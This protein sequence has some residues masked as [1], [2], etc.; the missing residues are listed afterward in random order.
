MAAAQQV[1]KTEPSEIIAG[2]S[3]TWLRTISNYSAADWVLNYQLYSKKDGTALTVFSSTASGTD[4]LIALTSTV[5]AAWSPDDYAA[6][7]YLT[8]VSQ[9]T[10]RVTVWTG[11][12][13]VLQNPTN[14]TNQGD[15][16]THAKRVLDLIEATIEGRATDDILNSVVEGTVIHRLTPEQLIMMRDRYR[17]E[18]ANEL[19]Q[20]K[21]DKGQ[22]TG[23][24]IL[25]RFVR[26]S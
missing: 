10:L 3:A 12:I 20:A 15:T 17:T 1:G 5:T 24:I 11:S 18:Y 8:A 23:R 14:P 9:P 19:A 16:R 22:A 7:A 6:T 4:F 2:D 25:S 26:P 13:L 21:L